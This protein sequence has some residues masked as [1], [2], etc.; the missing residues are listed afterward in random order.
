[1]TT[2]FEWACL[3]RHIPMPSAL[4]VELNQ[5]TN[6]VWQK[7]NSKQNGETKSQTGGKRHQV[8]CLNL[9]SKWPSVFLSYVNGR[10]HRVSVW[11]K[12]KQQSAHR[13]IYVSRIWAYNN[14]IQ[15]PRNRLDESGRHSNIYKGR[16]IGRI[17]ISQPTIRWEV[18]FYADPIC[19]WIEECRC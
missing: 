4:M 17:K 11:Y 16:K 12:K 1:M 5:E 2:I 10:V 19:F 15:Q 9:S 13:F 8:L 14:N 18:C 6:R 3:R 7:K